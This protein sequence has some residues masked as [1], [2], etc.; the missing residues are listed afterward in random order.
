M[1]ALI[2]ALWGN[3]THAQQLS[4]NQVI[5]RIVQ[6]EN[7]E[8]KTL[9]QYDPIVETYVQDLRPDNE[10]GMMS[11]TD[12]YFLGRA[13]LSE[14]TV[15]RP[16]GGK[17]NAKPKTTKL[18][19]LGEVFDKKFAADGFLNLIY[20]DS[21][22]FD[23]EHYRFDYV[24]REFLD[25]VRCLVFDVTA[26]GEKDGDH[27]LRR[28]WVVVRDYTIV[29]F[30]GADSS[31]EHSKGN[32]LHFDSWRVNVKPGVWVPAYIYSAESGAGDV[33][34]SRLLFQAQTLLWGYSP[35][36]FPDDERV[37]ESQA[38]PGR[39]TEEDGL[40][41]LQAAGLLAPVGSVD[42]VLYTIV[43]NLEVSNNLDIEPD[44]A[45]RVMLTSTL[46]SFTV[47]H[48]IL[49]SRGLL[50]MLP[51]EA[52]LATVLAHELGH[53]LSGHTLADRWAV[54]DWSVLV[55][56]DHFDHFDFPIDASVEQAANAKTIQ[57]LNGSPY[58]D[59]LGNSVQ[60][61]QMLGTQ[62]QSLPGLISPHL[63][64]EVPLANL[65]LTVAHS[66]PASKEQSISVLSMGS[67]I[68][69]N[70]WTSQVD[71][72]K[73]KPAAVV[74]NRKRQPFL[75]KPSIP[76]LVLQSTGGP[77]QKGKSVPTDPS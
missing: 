58:K 7:E 15:Q 30:N 75:I 49:I 12:H 41:R 29:R 76:H 51:D 2:T 38:E 5:D 57:L 27:F 3:V 16:S 19:G 39:E 65:L 11:I 20:V 71:L 67:R 73:S 44:V 1:T 35:K 52:S 22:A 59:K 33:L 10:L 61:L 36:T 55:V 45:C 62:T 40:D 43:N 32:R 21:N 60:F 4:T 31:A 53:I 69:L 8:M 50:D 25:E 48:T 23:R 54:R 66:T 6:R 28:I 14:G 18:G 13:F 64:R 77:E 56:E 42:K 47:G 46:E 9:H 37:M 70:P 74:S 68:D 63:I 26:L 24:R 72:Q 34:S 17:K